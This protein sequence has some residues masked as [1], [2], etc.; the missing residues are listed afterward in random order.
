MPQDIK[1]LIKRIDDSNEPKLSAGHERRFLKKLEKELPAG[2]RSVPLKFAI[3][4]SITVLISLSGYLWLGQQDI[5][6]S[7][8][9]VVDSSAEEQN[10]KKTVK[11][12][13]LSPDLKKIESYYTASINYELSKLDVS[14]TNKD[15]VDDYLKQLNELN[16]EYL[17]LS[18]EMNSYGPNDQIIG[19]MIKNLQL[20][21]QLL[22]NLKKELK[23][24]KNQENE[25]VT[26]TS[27]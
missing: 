11:L 2:K 7:Q 10:T 27:I 24:L 16:Q 8:N 14:E 23:H 6:G 19:A 13:D 25:D 12:G 15:I 26:N 1:E 22:Q 20:R 9:E 17:I 21:L 3:A 18:E 4:A 5:E